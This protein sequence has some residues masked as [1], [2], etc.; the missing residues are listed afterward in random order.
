MVASFFVLDP[1]GRVAERARAPECADGTLP[2][3]ATEMPTFASGTSMPSM[4][5]FAETSGANGAV[6]KTV[7]C[8]LPIGLIAFG[9]FGRN[10]SVTDD[11]T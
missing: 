6:T 4:S 7:E 9:V 1:S 5:D 3:D 2:V 11:C 10:D 8:G